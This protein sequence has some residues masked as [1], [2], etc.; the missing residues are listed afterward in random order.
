MSYISMCLVF[1]ISSYSFW[2]YF[3][4]STFFSSLRCS[5]TLSTLDSSLYLL[6]F[7]YAQSRVPCLASAVSLTIGISVGVSICSSFIA[8]MLMHSSFDFG[9]TAWYYE[10]NFA[11]VFNFFEVNFSGAFTELK[12]TCLIFADALLTLEKTGS[13]PECQAKSTTSL[14]SV[15]SKTPLACNSLNRRR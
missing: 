15:L 10:S 4:S 8:R 7:F 13:M 14:L 1:T 2:L 3:S 9:C 11:I 5:W 6:R 12:V